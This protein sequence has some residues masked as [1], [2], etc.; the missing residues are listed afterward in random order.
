MPSRKHIKKKKTRKPKTVID[1]LTICIPC[2][3]TGNNSKGG[4]CFPCGG[5]GKPR[6]RNELGY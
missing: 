4:V 1:A 2:D 5:T 3:G 6:K